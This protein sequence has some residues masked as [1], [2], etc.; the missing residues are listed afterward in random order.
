[1]KQIYIL[2]IIIFSLNSYSQVC[3]IGNE[4][5][6][7]DFINGPFGANLILGSKYTL[8]EEGTLR[9]INLIGN[10]TGTGVKMAV[11]DDNSG[12]P[13]DLITSFI[14]VVGNG[15]ISFS[16]T[17]TLLPAGDYW[18]MAVYET[19]GNHTD[20]NDSATGNPAYAQ[21]HTY[22]DAIPTNASGFFDVSSSNLDFLYFLE[23]DCGNTLST[24]HF[25][26]IDKIILYPNPSSD[27][28]QISSLIETKKYQI[29]N[30][31]GTLISSDI[32]SAN[33]N[34]NIINLTN[35]LYFLKLENG[36]TFKFIKE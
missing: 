23:I 11:Y 7:T 33:E 24:E 18:I 8:S 14:G 9:S 25:D 31:L 26:L 12:V 10:N 20:Y 17:P 2:A 6:T 4:T 16:V 5:T 22:G 27:F 35:G 32:I 36:S 1:M 30:S 21:N 29:Y 28:I 15:V 19:A 13:N 34:I 3:N